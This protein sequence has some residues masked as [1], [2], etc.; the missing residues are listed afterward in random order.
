MKY[1]VK[2]GSG[3]IILSRIWVACVTYRRVLDWM[4]GFIDNLYTPLGTIINYTAIADL[5]LKLTVPLS[6]SRFPTTDS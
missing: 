4:I 1:A 3:A 6:T 2:M 5:Y